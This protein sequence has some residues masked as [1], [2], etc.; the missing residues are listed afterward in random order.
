MA[1]STALHVID[2]LNVGGAQELLALLAKYRP[3]GRNMAVCVLQPD[4]EMAGRIEANGVPVFA[5]NRPRPSVA[6][7]LRFLAYALGSLRDIARLKKKLGADVIHGHLSDAEFLSI[8]A[9]RISRARKTTITFHTPL[10]LPERENPCQ[11]DSL[12][13]RR[14]N[15]V[16]DRRS[17][18]HG[19]RRRMLLRNRLRDRLRLWVMRLLYRQADAVVAVSAE[20]L[21]A[22]RDAIGIN[23]ARLVHIPNGV[24]CDLLASRRPPES[25]RR[26][27]GLEP[28]DAVLLNVGRLTAQK[29]Q[30]H[31]VKAL[32]ALAPDHPGLKLLIAGDG[33]D[34][35]ELACAIARLGLGCRAFL[36]GSRDDIADLLALADVVVVSS[37]WEGTSLSMM[38]S[39]AAGKTMA[40]TDV[41]GNRELLEDG[42]SALMFPPGDPEAMAAALGRL[43][44]GRALADRLAAAA[45]AKA[46]ESFDIRRVAAAYEDLWK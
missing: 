8:L 12:V 17:D 20:T 33:P 30:I 9:G 37:L 42:V 29:G 43:L 45:Q 34:R 41:A 1:P 4:L 6:S 28:G 32:A 27:L 39:M 31:L 19:D 13:N 40:V 18:R 44:T 25:L 5:L 14:I 46:R 35:E 2:A 23:P 21:I 15:R 16:R 10:L 7:P 24:D 38:E 26:E 36:L 22:L 11:P 3:P